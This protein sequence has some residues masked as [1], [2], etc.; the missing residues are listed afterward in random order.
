MATL[1]TPTYGFPYPDGTE[2]VADGDNAIGALAHAIEDKVLRFV[3][4]PATSFLAASATATAAPVDTAAIPGVPLDAV[5]IFA[6]IRV[7]NTVAAGSANRFTLHHYNA[8]GDALQQYAPGSPLGTNAM[9]AGIVECNAG[10]VKWS[11]NVGAGTVN[12]FA[13]VIGYLVAG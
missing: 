13:N 6:S 11:V 4:L 9:A 3:P 5:A 2:R 8:G 10:R 12:Y 1:T 7:N